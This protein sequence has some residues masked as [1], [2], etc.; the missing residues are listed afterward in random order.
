MRV[1]LHVPDALRI[2]NAFSNARN[3]LKDLEGL[4]DIVIVFNANAVSGVLAI[5]VPEDLLN[6]TAVGLY[7]CNNSITAN[8]IDVSKIPES[9]TI[10]PAAVIF[11][12]E[13]QLDGYVYL[14]P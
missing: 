2:E 10:V 4:Q 13:K 6:S 11:I 14:R 7:L 8:Q 5:S 9:F 3:I 12:I 1:I